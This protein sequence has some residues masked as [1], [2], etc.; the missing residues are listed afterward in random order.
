[1]L[2]QHAVFVESNRDL[3]ETNRVSGSAN[4]VRKWAHL[5]HCLQKFGG[6]DNPV[7]IIARIVAVDLGVRVSNSAP[8]P[9]QKA[10]P[11]IKLEDFVKDVRGLENITRELGR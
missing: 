7:C 2:L 1:V 9:H 11:E 10:R 3:C 4:D 6:C 8:S 5:Q